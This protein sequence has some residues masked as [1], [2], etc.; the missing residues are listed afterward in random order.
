MSSPNIP[1]WK[2]AEEQNKNDR[3]YRRYFELGLIGMAITSVDKNWIDFNDTLCNMLGYSR[4]DLAK[5]SWAELTHPEDLEADVVEFNH[6]LSGEIEG[7][8]M[9]KRFIS[10]DGSIVFTSM[11]VSAVRKTDGSIDYFIALI[12]N[13][14][15]QKQTEARL[16]AAKDEA[17]RANKAKSKFLSSMSHELRTPLT[18]ILGFAQLLESDEKT[19]LSQDQ[20]Q[21]MVHILSSGHHLLNLIND[22]LELTAIES[23]KIKL[24]IEPIQLK[25]AIN[26]SLTLLAPLAEKAN[27]KI[28][29]LSGFDITVKADHTKLKQ[30]I[31]NLVTNAIKYNREGGSISLDW[32]QTEN[33]TVR[34]STIDTGI[35]IS[36]TNQKKVFDSFNRLGNESSNIEGS[37]IGLVVTKNLIEMMGG[38]IGFESIEN[39]GSTFWFELPIAKK[40]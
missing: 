37:G 30:V 14:T 20:K 39:K 31:F 35:G 15:K 6:V 7:Y 3:R 38:Q 23:R 33:D 9:D 28:H 32:Q 21:S 26:D 12:S 13:I 11:S 19:P 36:G 8:S 34:I 40:A 17:E 4:E 25:A 22:L 16:I 29:A 18:A 24:S 27:I 5:L 2:Q 10:R 1:E